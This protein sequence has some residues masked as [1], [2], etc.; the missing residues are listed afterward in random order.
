MLRT[1][2]VVGAVL[3]G[4]VGAMLVAD[5]GFSPWFPFLALMVI[6][7]GLGSSYELLHLLGPNRRPEAWICD[8]G[9]VLVILSN[10]PAHLPEMK[11][12]LPGPW[13][14]VM[15]GLIVAILIVIVNELSSFREPGRSMERMALAVFAIAY[16]G[17]LPSFFVQLRWLDPVHADKG[18]QA[19]ALA[20][21]VPKLCDVGAYF[22]GRFLGRHK[23]S[24]VLSPKKTWEGA[25][26][27]L[28][29]AVLTTI[30]LDRWL[31][32]NVLWSDVGMEVAFG[33][34]VGVMGMLGDLAESLIKRDCQ[35]KD[36]S[37]AV[38]GFGGILDVIDSVV[39]PA[40]LV[41]G[42]LSWSCGIAR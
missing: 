20:V 42:W 8:L 33:L 21:F 40:P 16:L 38:P 13:P 2:L 24:P 25:A 9:I 10:W 32:G 34:S 39:L 31:P 28:A 27:G 6:F 23:M 4:L 14:W 17:L 3:I 36:A 1:R 29:A 15:G 26:G 22:A 11:G 12:W 19:L 30:A 18:T 41:Y 37:H 7:L 35:Q 5:Q